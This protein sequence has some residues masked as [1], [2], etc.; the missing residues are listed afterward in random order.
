MER[1]L[2]T[3]GL[4][5]IA[6]K[7]LKYLDL[8]DMLTIRKVSKS[9]KNSSERLFYLRLLKRLRSRFQTKIYPEHRPWAYLCDYFN[10]RKRTEDIKYF[11]LSMCKCY[12]ILQQKK[13]I[14]SDISP[15]HSA[16]FYGDLEVVKY[17]VYLFRRTRVPILNSVTGSR[18]T[19]FII[20]CQYNRFKIV[21]YLLNVN[22]IDY[23][24]KGD[25]SKTAFMFACQ[26]ACK[27][28][29]ELLLQYS[30]CKDIQLDVQD[31]K[32]FTGFIHA[33]ESKDEETVDIIL[34]KA[35]ELQLNLTIR[36]SHYETGF[37]KWPEK[38]P[39]K[40]QADFLNNPLFKYL[41]P[42][43][44]LIILNPTDEE[45]DADE[46]LENLLENMQ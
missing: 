7:I 29:V 10:Y 9:W 27:E 36:D 4:Q 5:A 26:F 25:G 19:A 12:K 28:T 43:S 37:Q 3:A 18:N 13:A 24:A 46:A 39:P 44:S 45:M 1:I 32:G 11:V 35:P 33:C 38:F 21:K 30:K 34:E 15:F 14:Y 31:E 2:N 16:V 40:M 17:F 22:G 42:Q 23:N 20:A 6:D 8:P 41:K